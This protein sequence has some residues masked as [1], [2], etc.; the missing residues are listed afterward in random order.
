[1]TNR[2]NAFTDD[3][4]G[5][6]DA[7]G[8]AEAIAQKK[9]S[10]QEA[11]EAAIQRAEKVNPN[12]DAIKVRAYDDARKNDKLNAEGAF[13]GVPTF[14]KDTDNVKGHPT[15]MGTGAYTS[16]KAK[17]NSK[18]VN[19]FLSTGVNC[20]GK[21]TLPEFGLLCSTEN[22]K[23]N[24]TRNP[25]NTEHTAGGSSSGSAALVASGAVPIASGNDG[26]GSIR[27]PAAICGLVGLKPTR[28][29]IYGMDGAELM[30]IG[31]VHQGVLTRSVRDTALFFAEAEKYNHN[32][33]LPTLGHIKHA[34]KKRLKIAM[35]ENRA[36]GTMGRQG[37][38]TWSLQLETAK[39]LESLGHKVELVPLPIDADSMIGDFL[40]YYGFLAYMSSHW[41]K[42]VFQAKVD[43]SQ[44]EPFT[45]GL[46]ER[47]KANKFKLP[48]S[49]K[50]MRIMGAKCSALF[51]QY[52]IVMTPVLAHR[53]P[54]VGHFS[55]E[56]SYDDV[57]K[58]AV[59]FAT[60]T[61]LYNITGE[62]AISLPMGQDSSGM[63]LGVQFAAP[64]GEDQ[65]LI[66]LAYELEEAKGWATIS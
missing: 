62:P 40:N 46:A 30:P 20:L 15:Q 41:G 21:T 47:F 16:K 14:I 5:N 64:Y 59:E 26:A 61:G 52:D 57:C 22:S 58:N 42:M 60:Y 2:I 48:K 63:P 1:M 7:T 10:V 9:I 56:L 8:V 6:L 32:K 49:I 39:I 3:A 66:E 38:E 35:L 25:W 53:T 23:W 33:R 28:N 43:K 31:I 24:V 45:L 34:N 18:F 50:A 19:Q 17:S 13:Y 44:L 37:E 51:K 27:I 4:L 55:P 65:R 36:E 54:K 12:L 11:V 29:R